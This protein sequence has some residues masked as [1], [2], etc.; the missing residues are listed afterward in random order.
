MRSFIPVLL[1]V[2]PG[3]LFQIYIMRELIHVQVGQCGNQV[4]TKFWETVAFEE[5]ITIIAIVACNKHLVK[6]FLKLNLKVE[7]DKSYARGL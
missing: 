6:F 5:K 2:R 7:I 3:Y 4:G 1:I